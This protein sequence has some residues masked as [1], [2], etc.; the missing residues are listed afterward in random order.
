MTYI[1]YVLIIWSSIF[2]HIIFEI[3]VNYTIFCPVCSCLGGSCLGCSGLGCSGLD[4]SGLG[5]S[6]L[7]GSGLDGS[8]L[9]GSGLDGSGLDGFGSG[10]GIQL[11][12][13]IVVIF[14][15]L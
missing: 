8:G 2:S 5:C 6:G 12:F 1:L 15:P 4:G 3:L 7:D 14:N 11:S 10:F 9:D 13:L